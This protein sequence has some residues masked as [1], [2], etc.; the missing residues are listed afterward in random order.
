[1]AAPLQIVVEDDTGR[2]RVVPFAQDE[3]AVGRAEGGNGLCLPERNVSRRHARFVRANGAVFVEDLDSKNGTLVNGERLVGR[4]RIREGDL[5]Q[6]G[7]YD[8][9]V[10]GSEDR[11]RERDTGPTQELP[12]VEAPPAPPP[13]PV[14]ARAEPAPPP[15]PGA[16]SPAPAPILPDLAPIAA[17]ATA[18]AGPPP[19]PASPPPAIAATPAPHAA[20]ASWRRAGF[21]VAVGAVSTFVGW[22][23]GS[24]LRLL[25]AG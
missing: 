15:L 14:P 5:V 19:S 12:A 6:I 20:P 8:L 24:V 1:V 2:R 16:A 25:R 3:I 7:D 11:A 22:A 4:R 13:L 10:E 23:A 18:A 9:A 17:E 21:Y